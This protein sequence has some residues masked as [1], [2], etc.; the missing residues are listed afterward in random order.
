ME[1]IFERK[2]TDYEQDKVY[3]MLGNGMGLQG[4]IKEEEELGCLG[5]Q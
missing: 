5:K 4:N 1:L 3:S 2:E